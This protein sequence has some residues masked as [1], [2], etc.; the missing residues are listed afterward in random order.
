MSNLNLTFI[1][2]DSLL[3]FSIKLFLLL[4]P[5]YLLMENNIGYELSDA[6]FYNFKLKFK[7]IIFYIRHINKNIT[8]IKIIL[9]TNLLLP[10]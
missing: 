6:Y 2:I 5:T 7:F 10:Q 3:T 4:R 8:I 9:N 1:S